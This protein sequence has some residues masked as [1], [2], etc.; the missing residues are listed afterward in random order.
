[1]IAPSRSHSLHLAG[2]KFTY[3]E[4]GATKGPLPP[5][6]R[7]IRRVG[8][9]GTGRTTFDAAADFVLSWSMHRAAGLDVR[10]TSNRATEGVDALLRM[11]IGALRIS[12]PVRVVYDIADPARAGFAYGTLEGHPERG[13]EAFVVTIGQDDFVSFHVVGFSRPATTLARLGGAAGR[14]L[15]DRAI[16]RYVKVVQR[17]VARE[18]LL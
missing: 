1:M 11:G 3:A 17:V 14:L 18:S 13:E 6:Y 16:D 7:H 2:R 10:A 9:L 12:A 15:Q 5:G 4:R 8:E